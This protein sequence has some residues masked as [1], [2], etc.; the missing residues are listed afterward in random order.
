MH[1]GGKPD[2]GRSE[3]LTGGPRG[4]GGIFYEAVKECV[5]ELTRWSPSVPKDDTSQPHFRKYSSLGVV[6]T[7]RIASK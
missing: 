1:I 5:I 3:D 7:E 6:W 2:T 4:A